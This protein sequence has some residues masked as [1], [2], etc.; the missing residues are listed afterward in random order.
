M[1][2]VQKI[3]NFFKDNKKIFYYFWF[4]IIIYL[5]AGEVS[6]AGNGTTAGATTW[7]EQVIE[8]IEWLVEWLALLVA[9]FTYFI[10]L[11]LDP[12]WVNW[13]IFW[14]SEIFRTIWTLVSNS[15]YIIFA[16]ILI[17][18]AFMNIIGKWEK[19][20]LK[21][22]LPKFIIW[23]LIVPFTWFFVQF[24][25]SISSILT[26]QVLT[27]PSDI[28]PEYKS[29]LENV[30]VSTD[31]TLNLSADTTKDEEYFDCEEGKEE[32]L[33]ESMKNTSFWLVSTYTYWI[34]KLDQIT[35]IVNEEF[36]VNI[37]DIWDLIIKIV[38]DLLFIIVYMILIVSL[39]LVLIVRWFYI[40]IYIMLSPLF[41]LMYFFDKKDW[42]WDWFLSKFNIK[43]FLSLAFIPV[44]VMLA[45][46]F[47]LLF[48]HT[49][50]TWM[51]WYW[52]TS[53]KMEIKKIDKINDQIKIWPFSLTIKWAVWTPNSDENN[54]MNVLITWWEWVLWT[55]WTMVL[56]LM[57][58]WVFR[59]SIMAAL[60]TSDITKAVVEPIYQFGNQ[61][62]QLVAKSPQYAPVFGG[63]Q[64]MKS[65][66]QIW[67]AANTYY[68]S[69]K[70]S[71]DSRKF[72]QEHWLFWNTV[73]STIES[74]K[75]SRMLKNKATPNLIA[76][77]IKQLMVEMG[78][79]NKAYTNKNWV[80]AMLEVAHEYEVEWWK[81]K[82]SIW[83][84]DEYV[85]LMKAIDRKL[86]I[87]DILWNWQG[88]R[89]GNWT[90]TDYNAYIDSLN[91][92]NDT[93]WW[94]TESTNNT[95]TLNLNNNTTLQLQ[96]ETKGDDI[97]LASTSAKA[98]ADAIVNWHVTHEQVIEQFNN[99]DINSD[100][101]VK[102]SLEKI[103]KHIRI[104]SDWN[105]NLVDEWWNMDVKKFKNWT[106]EAKKTTT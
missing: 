84:E 34:L 44:Y 46:T 42:W 99:M 86:G 33:S 16:F 93:T 92:W 3:K 29:K 56:Y 28:I 88:H 58:I 1:K 69:T 31:C 37:K 82:K 100:N 85:E 7:K 71:E 20:E 83:S 76:D 25:L 89:D 64:S 8:V 36:K 102:D 27:L 67:S 106:I 5:M 49:I 50:S 94:N 24:I 26:M 15:V 78:H 35:K 79:T 43:E 18:I 38:F 70:P 45:L 72:M 23:V 62:W 2:I 63:G 40:W 80:Q 12:G 91:W 59:I 19:W 30:V 60:R 61:V 98:L 101:E 52:T 75:L 81:D 95:N 11:F 32:K 47:W 103:Q 53:E 4:F 41:G 17:W 57:W 73:N 13:S 6:F 74:D 77:Q 10:T 87:N 68:T 90:K 54:V 105:K 51:T 22:T 96:T 21:Q 66:Q 48:I 39:G 14:L 104:D 97:V 9:A 65:I 55:I